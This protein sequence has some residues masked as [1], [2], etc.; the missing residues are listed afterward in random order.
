MR[1][2][3]QPVCFL[4]VAST[5]LLSLPTLASS[6]SPPAGEV[7]GITQTSFGT[8]STYKLK[9][10]CHAPNV[11]I[12]KIERVSSFQKA[13]STKDRPSILSHTY[14]R[15]EANLRGSAQTTLHLVLSGGELDQ[16]TQPPSPGMMSPIVGR[17]YLL[18]F[19]PATQ[20]WGYVNKGDPAV[21]AFS[22]LDP[23]EEL[24]GESIQSQWK[25]FLMDHC[26][27]ECPVD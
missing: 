14:L 23:N 21:M 2:L 16:I 3:Q 10:L 18:A 13:G 1:S 12:G 25:S 19:L 24:D 15:T 26:I 22:S 7:R 6:V 20:A 4:V 17:R 9:K 27:E 11:V 8:F 5:L